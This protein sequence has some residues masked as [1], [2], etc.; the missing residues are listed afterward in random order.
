MRPA[1]PQPAGGGRHAGLPKGLH[2]LALEREL[3]AAGVRCVVGMDEVG[4]GCIAGPVGVG[5]AWFDLPTLLAGDDP[6]AAVPPGIDDSKKLTRS[7]RAQRAESIRQW[8]PHTAVAYA[9]PAEI[10]A[11]GMT[12]AQCLAGRRALAGLPAAD[13]VLLDGSFDWLSRPLTLD[14]ALHFGPAADVAVPA[15]RTFIKGDGTFVTIAAASV[16]AKVDRDAHMLELA[17]Q[18]PGYGWEHNAGYPSPAHKAAVA[19]LGITEH[20]RRSFKLR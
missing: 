12:M 9:Q 16:L 15:V 18:C 13:V 5:A 14:A 11:L 6:E 2:D 4:R 10:D 17:A 19:Q 1:L 3:L 20:H 8:Q 7:A